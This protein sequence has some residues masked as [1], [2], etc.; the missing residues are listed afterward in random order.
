MIKDVKS[1]INTVSNRLSKAFSMEAFGIEEQLGFWELS[2]EHFSRKQTPA[3]TDIVNWMDH[4][5]RAPVHF[6]YKLEGKTDTTPSS[7]NYSKY[8]EGRW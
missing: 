4:L 7:R 8:H 3:F 6:V 2:A 5:Y 1:Y